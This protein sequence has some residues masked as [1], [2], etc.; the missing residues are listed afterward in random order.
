MKEQGLGD[1]AFKA[2]KTSGER[3]RSERRGKRGRTSGREKE[4]TEKEK[5]IRTEPSPRGEEK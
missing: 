4:E 1:T 2:E 3:N 5:K